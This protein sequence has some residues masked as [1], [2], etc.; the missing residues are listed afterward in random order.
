MDPMKTYLHVREPEHL[1]IHASCSL[2]CVSWVVVCDVVGQSNGPHSSG[3][4][5]RHIIMPVVGDEQTVSGNTKQVL[6][7]REPRRMRPLPNRVRHILGFWVHAVVFIR[8][9]IG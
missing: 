5:A 9:F 4:P 1:A 7:K 2:E 6:A 3:A 8:N